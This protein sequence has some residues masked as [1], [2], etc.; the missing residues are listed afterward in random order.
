MPSE[1]VGMPARKKRRYDLQKEPEK[2]ESC[3]KVRNQYLPPRNNILIHPGASF[4]PLFGPFI[5]NY[6]VGG[7]RAE[8]HDQGSK[9]TK[10]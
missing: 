5:P 4:H 9:G 8:E 3:A 6:C 2:E 7:Q 1:K 10:D